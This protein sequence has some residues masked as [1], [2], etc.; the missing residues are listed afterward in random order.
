MRQA[1]NKRVLVSAV[2]VYFYHLKAILVDRQI[3]LAAEILNVNNYRIF[4]LFKF[5]P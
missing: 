4:F 3:T 1:H 5:R 2:N